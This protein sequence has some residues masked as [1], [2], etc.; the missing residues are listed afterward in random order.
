MKSVE[1]LPAVEVQ[2]SCVPAIPIFVE[3][4]GSIALTG[5]VQAETTTLLQATACP[6]S[7]KACVK[8]CTTWCQY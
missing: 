1:A 4:C 8:S 3:A 2:G 6:I 7:S 5:S